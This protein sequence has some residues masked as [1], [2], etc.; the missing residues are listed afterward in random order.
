[1]KISRKLNVTI[2]VED[3]NHCSSNCWFLNGDFSDKCNLFNEPF[4]HV[5]EIKGSKPRKC[6][7][8]RVQRCKDMFRTRRGDKL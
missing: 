6:L 5:S 8:V 3:E 1:M 2:E 4:T 7:M